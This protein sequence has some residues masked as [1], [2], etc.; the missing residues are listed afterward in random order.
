[1]CLIPSNEGVP[2]GTKKS[3]IPRRRKVWELEEHFHCS[4]VGTCLTLDELRRLCRRTRIEIETPASDYKVHIAIVSAVI[5]KSPVARLVN[6]HLDRK[7]QST[8]RH[9][10]RLNSASELKN[11][12]KEMV[13]QGEIAAAYWSL[14]THPL[15]SEQLLF[16]VYGEVHMLS[17]LSGA[18]TRIDMQALVRLRRRIPELERELVKT[19]A[20]LLRRMHEK[21]GVIQTLDKRL[22]ESLEVEHKLRGDKERLRILESGETLTHLRIQNEEYVGKLQKLQARVKRSEVVEEEQRQQALTHSSRSLCLEGQLAELAAERDALEV[23]LEKLL[24]PDCTQ[25]EN[26]SFC[27]RDIDLCGRCILYVGGRNRLCAHF[28][29]LVE[30]QN[31]CF[32][33]HD[34]GQEESSHRLE[35]LLSGADA[36]LCP[37]DCVSHDAVHRIKRD[38]KRQGKRLLLLPKSSLSSFTKGLHELAS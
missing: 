12:W 20:E 38:C 23:T 31:G 21:D 26:G 2:F 19:R 1:M 27:N 34:G 33:H 25:C 36:V 13:S 35:S 9:F 11:R 28:R 7:Y 17:H 16:R 14:V 3:H 30:R 5:D 22:V 18:S 10:A 37:L 24:L 15:A 29:A 8:I 4:I 32:I 6:K